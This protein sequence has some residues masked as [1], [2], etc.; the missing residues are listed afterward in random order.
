MTAAIGVVMTEHIV[1]GR[2]TGNLG[3]Q[4]LVG[5]RLR[6][7][8]DAAETE[9]LIGVP[10]SELYELLAGLIEP[11]AKAAD[12]PVAAI[13]IAVPGVVRSGVVEDAPNL[14][15]IKGL[16]LAEALETVLRAHGVSAPVHV[17]NDADSVAAGLAAR[18]G[19]LDRLIRVWTL[20]NGIG[21]GRWPIA[22]GV[23]EGGHTVVTLDPR[24]RYCG[25]GGVGHIEGIMGNRAMRLRFLDLEPEDIF[26]NARAGDQRCRE[27]VD[28][29]HRA[30]AAGCAS[31]IHLGGPGKFYFTG[32]NVC[33]LDL[34]V[35]REHLETMVRMSP[36][37][38]YSLEV[39]PAD[40]STSVLGAGV[41]AL[42]AQQ[43]W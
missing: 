39:L 3:Q 7:P 11:L 43:N 31:A 27:F 42:R 32:L 9:A 41:A 1:A 12:E 22:D 2:L 6:Y 4:T 37:Q 30:L 24:E 29:W 14:A 25:C 19:H 10:T 20:G 26:A 21:Y 34:K 5:E 33:F 13:G 16:R 18:G 8:E 38:S 17:L 28:L 36:L 23:W 40:D 15:Q 35:L